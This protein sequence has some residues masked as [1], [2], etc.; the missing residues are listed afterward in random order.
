MPSIQ[1]ITLNVLLGLSLLFFPWWVSLAFAIALVTYFDAYEILAWGLVAD[2][3]YSS[4]TPTYMSFEFFMTACATVLL[5]VALI[6][7]RQLVFY[8]AH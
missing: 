2:G 1:R 3:L 6:A 7:K 4:A 5:I 8:E